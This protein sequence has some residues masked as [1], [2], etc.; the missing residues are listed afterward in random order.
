[1]EI[2]QRR[3]KYTEPIGNQG[4]QAYSEYK[5][6]NLEIEQLDRHLFWL[7][8]EGTD[9][10]C[11]TSQSYVLEIRENGKVVSS[12]EFSHNW[13]GY[14]RRSREN[15]FGTEALKAMDFGDLANKIRESSTALPIED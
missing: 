13:C 7:Q 2:N 6:T 8:K 3:V 1:M 11:T 4:R 15:P 10:G 14:E 9:G 5:L 12:G